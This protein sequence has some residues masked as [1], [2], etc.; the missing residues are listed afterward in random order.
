MCGNFKNSNIV[1][2]QDAAVTAITSCVNQ[3]VIQSFTKNSVLNNVAQQTDQKLLTQQKGVDL[4][5][6]FMWIGIIVGVLLLLALIGAAIYFFF[7]LPKGSSKT[8][9]V[10]VPAVIKT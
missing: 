4:G 8:T 1:I 2:T 9:I 5:K 3:A 6:I 7:F 10:S